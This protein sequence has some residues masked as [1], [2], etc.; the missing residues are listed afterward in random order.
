M[1]IRAKTRAYGEADRIMQPLFENLQLTLVCA[2]QCLNVLNGES[3]KLSIQE[4]NCLGR[5]S[6][7][8]RGKRRRVQTGALSPL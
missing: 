8:M 6:R 7:H 5:L 1:D 3:E 4:S 2:Q